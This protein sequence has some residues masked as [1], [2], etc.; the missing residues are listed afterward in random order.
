MIDPPDFVFGL[1]ERWL[2]GCSPVRRITIY[3]RGWGGRD[4]K[5]GVRHYVSIRCR[6]GS[7]T[8][9]DLFLLKFLYFFHENKVLSK[10]RCV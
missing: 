7:R 3:A 10:V 5:A 8:A 2:C 1:A 9:L 6:G 4:W